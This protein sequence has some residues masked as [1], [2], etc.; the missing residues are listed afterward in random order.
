[1]KPDLLFF[2]RHIVRMFGA[3]QEGS[4]VNLFI[5][6]MAGGS[7]ANLLDKHGAFAE[8]VILR[9]THQ[10]LLGLHYLHSFGILH[11]DLKGLLF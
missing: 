6:W 3:V 11:R 4:T 9:Y 1:M 2:Y 7:V 8:S 10:I 5:E